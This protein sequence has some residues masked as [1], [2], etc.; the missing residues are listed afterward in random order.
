VCACVRACVRVCAHVCAGP[1]KVSNIPRAPEPAR[2]AST[3]SLIPLH[4]SDTLER[5]ADNRPSRPHPLG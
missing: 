1:T 4:K 3:F 5:D 2:P